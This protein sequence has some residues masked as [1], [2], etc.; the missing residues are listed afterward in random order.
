[1]LAAGPSSWP[2][3]SVRELPLE[4]R[5]Q[6]KQMT[7]YDPLD[8]HGGGYGSSFPFDY[9]DYAHDRGYHGHRSSHSSTNYNSGYGYDDYDSRS[10]PFFL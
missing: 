3:R 4:E 8:F 7:T 9:D 5:K 10:R 6:E 2:M 1:M